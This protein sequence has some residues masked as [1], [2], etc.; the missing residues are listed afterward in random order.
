MQALV[1]DDSRAVRLLVGNILREQGFDVVAAGHGQEGLE[2]LQENPEIQLV[3][4]DW[5]MPV[6]NGL[7][8]IQAVRKVRAWDEVRLVMV[9]TETESEQ[10]QRA[11]NAGANEYV[12]KPFT[13]EV[14]VAKLSLLGAF[15]D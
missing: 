13:A 4:V 15:E 9:T 1:I 6:M 8:F 11:I 7:E 10:V 14:L 5:N 3:L 12:M 2:R